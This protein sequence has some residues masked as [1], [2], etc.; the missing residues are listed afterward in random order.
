MLSYFLCKQTLKLLH[1]RLHVT[2][3]VTLVARCIIPAV[4]GKFDPA[5]AFLEWLQFGNFGKFTTKKKKTTKLP[6]SC[7]SP[8]RTRMMFLFTEDFCSHLNRSSEE[9]R[10]N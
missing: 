5:S 8:Y 4:T 9:E 1:K 10:E 2:S 7:Y 3:L 6:V